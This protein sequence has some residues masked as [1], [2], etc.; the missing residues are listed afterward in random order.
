MHPTCPWRS[1]PDFYLRLHLRPQEEADTLDVPCGGSC[2]RSACLRSCC[3]CRSV[4]RECRAVLG[5]PFL[6][7][8]PVS[9]AHLFVLWL[10]Q[11]HGRF[12]KYVC[13]H[14]IYACRER[15]R[16]IERRNRPQACTPFAHA[17]GTTG[18]RRDELS[19]RIFRI[20][21]RW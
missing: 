3:T 9:P 17:G 8:L 21:L 12:R 2:T 6:F 13:R 14:Q 18:E 7:L 15:K 20:W 5:H 10:Q 19:R 1:A 4:Q 11:I 16:E